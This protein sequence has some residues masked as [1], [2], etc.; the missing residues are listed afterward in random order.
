MPIKSGRV[1]LAQVKGGKTM[2]E[3][4]GQNGPAYPADS[5]GQG[6]A[7]P[8]P[9]GPPARTRRKLRI[10]IISL[11]SGVVLLG[12]AAVGAYLLVNHL[13]G[14]IHRVPVTLPKVPGG[15]SAEAMT[16]LVTSAAEPGSSGVIML[17]HL[18]ARDKRGGVV[19]IPPQTLVQVPGHGLKEI[20]TVLGYGGASLLVKTVEQLT[21]VQINHYARIKFTGVSNLVNAIG[22][23]NVTL[24]KKTVS[25][26]Y[27]F[28]PGVNHLNGITA[29][30]YVRN[31]SISVDNRVLQ[32]Q[33]LLR[34]ILD[35]IT[36]GHMLT[37]PVTAYH[38]VNA[39]VSMLT[40]DSNF[41]N[42]EVE[43]LATGLDSISGSGGTFVTAPTY[44]ASGHVYLNSSESNQLWAAI[45]TD[46]IAAF[47]AKYPATLTPSVP[48]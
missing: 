37:N 46:S 41:T 5:A 16:V 29:V 2:S 1:D 48:S 32:Q 9:P 15:Q 7:A 17:M 22:G 21:H 26:G 13:A 40:V 4:S 30:Y 18:D 24:A 44:T 12:A 36:S 10:F 42:S 45:R 20:D 31:P 8:Q 3:T 33:N 38:V 25:G 34:S 19:S 35:R 6:S 23:V 39:M 14:G 47:A 28:H 27:T 11:A 43:S